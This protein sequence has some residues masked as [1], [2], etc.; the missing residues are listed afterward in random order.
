MGLHFNTAKHFC[1]QK[2]R[3]NAVFSLYKQK[4]PL[5]RR[6]PKGIFSYAEKLFS[7][8]LGEEN[9]PILSDVC[10]KYLLNQ[11]NR[12]YKTLDFYKLVRPSSARS[13]V[14]SSIYSRS[15]PTGTPLA[16]RLTFTP[17]G[18]ISLLMYIAVVSP[19]IVG[20]VATMIS[21]V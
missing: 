3:N 21:F 17:I 4:N 9:Y 1:Q 19:S 20:L 8:S 18:L 13:N 16:I 10:E 7:F 2:P 14:T 11:T 6:V 5:R 12:K 15:P